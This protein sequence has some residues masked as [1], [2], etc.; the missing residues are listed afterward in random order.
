QRSDRAIH[1]RAVRGASSLGDTHGNERGSGRQ[2]IRPGHGSCHGRTAVAHH[3][4][5]NHISAQKEKI[6][7]GR[8]RDGQIRRAANQPRG[9]RVVVAR[10]KIH[11]HTAYSHSTHHGARGLR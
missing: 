1:L 2:K 3:H 7:R 6:G 5:V 8:L 11:I 4:R 10:H 9:G